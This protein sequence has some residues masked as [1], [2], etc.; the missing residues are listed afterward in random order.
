[1]HK[2]LLR[3]IDASPVIYQAVENLRRRLEDE[4]FTELRFGAWKLKAGGKYYVTRG[5]GAIVALRVPKK[6]PKGF[7]IATAHGDS[8]C[9]RIHDGA[10]LAGEYLRLDAEKYGGPNLGTWMDRPLGI[11]GRVM[12]RTAAGVE[13]RLVDTKKAVAI[14]PSMPPQLV[15]VNDGLKLDPAKDLIAVYGLGSAKGRF[16]A[17]M[18]KLAKCKESEIVSTDLYLYVCEKGIVW[19]ANGEFISAPRFDDLACAFTCMEGFLAADDPVDRV[20]V[21]AVFDHEEVGSRSKQGAGSNLLQSVLRAA[22]TALGFD[23][24][25]FLGLLE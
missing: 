4:G 2:K 11:A 17:D 12:V 24:T 22:A 9:F 10:E 13:A 20:Q 21:C 8:P 15:K 7:V 18:A 25:A 14:M 3:F 6:K 1:M 16:L 19:G 23:E 5:G